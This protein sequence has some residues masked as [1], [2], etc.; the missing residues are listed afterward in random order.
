MYN[1]GKRCRGPN[2]VVLL[3]ISNYGSRHSKWCR[4]KNGVGC[5]TGAPVRTT[6]LLCICRLDRKGA[7]AIG[8]L[9]LFVAIE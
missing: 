8:H 5:A 4:N 7:V 2:G 9:E 1:K 3:P 6:E